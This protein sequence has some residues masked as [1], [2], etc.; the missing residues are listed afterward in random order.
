MHVHALD[1]AATLAGIEHRAINEHRRRLR[2]VRIRR[3]IRAILAAQLE[4]AIEVPL[5]RACIN[6]LTAAH[7][8]GEH[9]VIDVT[10]FNQPRRVR[11][12]HHHVL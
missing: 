11:V 12:V 4:V 6:F 7:R 2:H 9:H 5:R 3:H 10:L 8:A 1:A